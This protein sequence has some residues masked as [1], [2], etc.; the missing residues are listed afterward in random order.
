MRLRR[1]AQIAGV[2]SMV[3][4][5]L[6]ACNGPQGTV[7]V[8][9]AAR[10][11]PNRTLASAY[12][13]ITIPHKPSSSVRPN[14]VSPAT[15]SISMVVSTLSAKVV[16]TKKADLTQKSPGCAPVSTG[17]RCTI[18]GISLATGSYKADVTAY[19][20]TQ[21]RGQVLS[22]RHSVPFTLKAGAPQKIAFTMD[23]IPKSF[24]VVP[25]S[26]SVAGSAA[27]G[28]KIGAAAVWGG[29]E[30][31]LVAP[32]D[33]DGDAIVGAGSPHLTIATSNDSFSLVQPSPTQQSFSITPPKKALAASTEI[34]IKASYSDKS[35]CAQR[36]ARCLQTIEV[37]YA[38]FA[39][40]DWIAFAHDFQ[41]T[42]FQKQS[43]RVSP[44][45]AATLKQRW[46]ITLPDSV[47]SSPLVYRGNVI[48]PA[49]KGTVYNLS[50]ADGSVIWKTTIS[51]HTNELLRSSP[52]IDVDDGLVLMGTWYNTG[53]DDITPHPSVLYALRLSDG[54]VAWSVNFPGMVHAPPVY[55]RGVVYEGW[56]GGDQPF[57]INGGV[58]AINS[59]TGVARWT[60]LTNPI[61]NPGGG[62]GVWGA[63]AWDGSHIVFGTGNTC[64]GE[65]YDQGA[66]ALNADGS[67]A[68]HYQADPTF[69][70]D[71]DTGGGVLIQNS[72][73]TFINKNGSLYTL[74]ASTGHSMVSTPLG[75]FGGHATPTSD[76]SIIVVGAGFFPQSS[77][78]HRDRSI[79][80]RPRTVEPGFDSYLKA[81]DG[82]GTVVWSLPM[83]A[84]MDSY[85]AIN[86][87]VAFAGMD[88]NLNVISLQSGTILFQIAGGAFDAGPVIVPSGLYAA[89]YAGNVYAY[90]LP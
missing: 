28:F 26:G 86:N 88:N 82:T 59:T 63:L 77:K 38:P 2:T 72:T 32:L 29:A 46:K 19:S 44:S 14:Y 60:W 83:S 17:T 36:G 31:F 87:G 90:S 55:A 61:T 23:G 73:A 7:S 11:S 75:G 51:T 76:G 9:P 56:S 39:N 13:V 3:T 85:V 16:L 15:Q 84:S 40:D 20:R 18:T 67:M 58:Q 6:V 33:A 50:A 21:E 41:R 49:Y 47:Y 65:A 64:Q 12:F 80:A 1:I 45:N 4:S 79:L 5:L 30:K 70:D 25:T 71:N 22:A 35:I 37:S 43:T 27:K 10:L 74:D 68:W 78:V 66:V 54:S 52:A 8:V 62:G 48:V 34:T 57:C 53:G 69:Q 24:E 42:G 89:D 81:V